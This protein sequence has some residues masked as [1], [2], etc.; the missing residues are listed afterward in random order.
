MPSTPRRRAFVSGLIF[1]LG[2]TPAVSLAQTNDH[3][4]ATERRIDSVIAQMTLEEKLGQLNLVPGD[5]EPGRMEIRER[6]YQKIRGGQVG[7]I[8]NVHGAAI[9]TKLQNAAV[10]QSRLKI[11]LLFGLDVIHG[12]RTT[13]PIPLAEASTWDPDVVEDAARIAAAEASATGINWTFAPMVDIARDPRWGRI[14]EGSGEDPYLGSVMATARVRGFQGNDLRDP[15][16]ILACAKHY[17]AYGGA[18][19]GR[20]YNTVDISERTLREV[21]LP[22]FHA[23]VDAGAGSLMSSFNEIGGIPSTANH[24]TLTD[25]LRG[26][27]K[28]DGFVVSD[29]TSVGELIPHGIARDSAEAGWRALSAGVDMDMAS[30]IYIHDLAPLVQNKKIPMATVDTAVRRVLREKF[31]LGLFDDPTRQVTPEHEKSAM[32]TPQAL[33][34]AR[35]DAR[36]AIVMLKNEKQTLPLARS[37]KTVA[38]IGPLAGDSAAPLGPWDGMGKA[39]NVVSVLE[40]LRRTFGKGT[41]ILQA[42]GCDIEGTSRS[43]FD[44]AIATASRADVAILVLGENADMSGEAAS[45]SDIG[46]PGVQEELLKAV[47]A[48]RTP[49]VLVLMNGRPLT[50]PWAAEHVPAILETWFLGVQAGPAIADVMLGDYNPGGKLPVSFPRSVGQIPLYYNHKSTGRPA[51]STKYTSK[52][53]DGPNEPL[54][55]FGFGLSYTQFT[56]GKPVLPS[57]TIRQGQALTVSVAVTNVGKRDGDEVVQLYIRDEVA[58]VTRPV[59]ELKGFQRIHLKAGESRQ[60][61]FT[62]T[63]DQLAVLDDEMKPRIEPGTFKVFVGSDARELQEESFDVVE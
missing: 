11:P 34:V 37:L 51:D 22:P 17:V 4:D 49:V 21:Y 40:G 62:L 47:V 43:G 6:L 50:I 28:F 48:T 13:F 18:E 33:E 39:E 23:A 20:D 5:W 29:W 10:H 19:G 15:S 31:R 56:I 8:L 16:R 26:E 1:L 63:P 36:E 24:H 14:A 25:I 12:F 52:Y 55:P 38:L 27:W 32:L 61:Q 54:Y 35:R 59:L 44:E 2:C 7:A 41:T 60:V 9:T 46:L 57:R 58:H 53:I 3:Q 30:D 45:R 42:R